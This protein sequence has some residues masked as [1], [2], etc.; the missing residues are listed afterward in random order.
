[1]TRKLINAVVAGAF[2]LG[3]AGIAAAQPQWR[4]GDPEYNF[5]F[6]RGPEWNPAATEGRC[7]LRIYVDDRATVH[8]RGDQIIVRTTSGKQSFDQGS[9]CSQPLP[10]HRVENFRVV[11]ERGRG[12]ITDVRPPERRNNFTGSIGIVDP[13]P[14]GETYVIDV[15]WSN[16]EGLPARPLASNDPYPYFDESRAC[17]DRVRS[18]FLSRNREDAYL[19]F[20]G[21]PSREDVGSNRERIVGQAFARNRIESRPIRY[22]CTLNDRT[23]RVIAANYEL[24]AGRW[25]SVLR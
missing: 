19:E 2:A 14:A 18:E 25:N 21:V 11:A 7:R 5:R 12:R 15:A 24:L 20:T 3:M 8:L 6:S 4:P 22:E 1:M 10:F 13:D 9:Q 16:A 17:Q 23:N